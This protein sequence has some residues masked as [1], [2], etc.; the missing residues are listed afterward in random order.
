MIRQ[1]LSHQFISIGL[2][3]ILA[4]CN[5]IAAPTLPPTTTSFPPTSTN[6]PSTNTP[7]LPTQTPVLLAPSSSGAGGGWEPFSG[8]TMTVSLFD[9]KG[10]LRALIKV[11]KIVEWDASGI[12]IQGKD[13][14]TEIQTQGNPDHWYKIVDS[15]IQDGILS[16]TAENGVYTLLTEAA[17]ASSSQRP[18]ANASITSDGKWEGQA[19]FFITGFSSNGAALIYQDVRNYTINR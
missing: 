10:K 13:A 18:I 12:I 6:I 8:Q 9:D 19:S 5:S 4:G 14:I 7:A 2:V 16:I 3:F 11:D 15:E 1:R 17:I